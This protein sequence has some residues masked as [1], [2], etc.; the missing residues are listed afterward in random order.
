MG[1]RDGLL[2]WVLGGAG[3]LFLYAAY[4]KQHPAAVLSKTLGT[5]ADTSASNP[6]NQR[7]SSAPVPF[8]GQRPVVRSGNLYDANGNMIGVVPKGYAD[9]PGTYIPRTTYA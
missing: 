4:T 9:N 2:L 8:E 3:V 5:G 1:G 6:L 7:E